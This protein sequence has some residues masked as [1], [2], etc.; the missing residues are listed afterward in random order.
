[1]SIEELED[2]KVQRLKQKIRM[3][4]E[5]CRLLGEENK[6]LLEKGHRDHIDLC[7]FR[8]VFGEDPS[9]LP[10]ELD[11]FRK[12]SRVPAIRLYRA[13]TGRGLK[14]SKDALE[15]ALQEMRERKKIR[16]NQ[17]S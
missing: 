12:G 8:Q 2:P 13:R 1:M 9:V 5:D 11:L 3:L 7:A 4:E 16:E 10:I 15:N 6:R 14:E 17:Q